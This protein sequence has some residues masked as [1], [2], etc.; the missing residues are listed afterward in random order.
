MGPLFSLVDNGASALP[1]T[2]AMKGLLP[3]L[4]NMKGANILLSKKK[5][6]EVEALC[7]LIDD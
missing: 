6:E 1:H 7:V 2:K 3:T 4:K 5:M